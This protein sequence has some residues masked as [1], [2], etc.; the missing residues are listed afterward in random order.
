MKFSYNT[1]LWCFTVKDFAQ[2][3]FEWQKL[4]GK[5][6]KLDIKM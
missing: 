4:H 5:K 1:G 6:G 2:F 3:T